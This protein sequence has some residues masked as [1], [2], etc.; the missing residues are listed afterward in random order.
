MTMTHPCLF[1]SQSSLCCRCVLG[2]PALRWAGL[3]RWHF[4]LDCPLLPESSAHLLT[5]SRVHPSVFQEASVESPGTQDSRWLTLPILQHA[6]QSVS[7]L[8]IFWS[9]S[10]MRYCHGYPTGRV[11]RQPATVSFSMGSKEGT[12]KPGIVAPMAFCALFLL[13]V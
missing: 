7:F 10:W 11:S 2:G 13:F 6:D 1:L 5:Q 4:L 9:L 12:G 3:L 8:S